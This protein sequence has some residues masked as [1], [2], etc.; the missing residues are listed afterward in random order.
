MSVVCYLRTKLWRR[1]KGK[2]K[3]EKHL[4]YLEDIK[5]KSQ[6][7]TKNKQKIKKQKK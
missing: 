5:N 3:A 6:R 2:S 1:T 7:K 4:S